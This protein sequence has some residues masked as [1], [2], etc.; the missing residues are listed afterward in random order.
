MSPLS[1]GLFKNA[2]LQSGTAYSDVT[3][4]TKSEALNNSKKFSQSRGCQDENNWINCLKKLD[5]KEVINYR[6]NSLNFIANQ[7]FLP[8]VGEAFY[9]VASFEALKKGKFNSGINILAGVTADEGTIFVFKWFDGIDSDPSKL[10]QNIKNYLIKN[11][12][13][14]SI[15]SIENKKKVVDYYISDETDV[16]MIKNKT[17]QIYGDYVLSCPTYY[18]PRD[19]VLWSE[20]NKVFMYQLTYKSIMSLSSLLAG[21][22]P[23]VGIGH[24][25]D[26]EFVMGTS[27]LYPERYS[28]QDYQFAL[29]VMNLWSNFAKTG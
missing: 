21:N 27:I 2:I 17:A 20:D 22:E 12:N 14:K 4:M 1:S 16:N 23:W 6:F 24:G 5:A 15:K 8:V 10:N 28:Q 13:W 9:P 26:I 25:D 29:F 11:L 19:M 3:F 7:H 18:M